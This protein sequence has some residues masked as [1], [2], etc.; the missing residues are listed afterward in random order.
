MD[1]K[2]PYEDLQKKYLLPFF[3]TFSETKKSNGKRK[4]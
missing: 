4:T 3:G 1:Y 2:N